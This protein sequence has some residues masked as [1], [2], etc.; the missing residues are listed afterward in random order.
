MLLV[1]LLFKGQFLWENLVDENKTYEFPAE[2][3]VNISLVIILY[4]SLRAHL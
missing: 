4:S 2:M 1:I 3:E